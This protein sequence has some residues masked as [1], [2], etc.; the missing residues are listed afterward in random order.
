MQETNTRRSFLARSAL[1]GAALQPLAAFGQ[2]VQNTNT[3]SSP[4]ALRITDLKCAYV[5]GSLFVKI[6]TN[7][8][9]WGCGEAVDAIGG[10]YHMVQSMGRQLRN[11]SPL[12]VN[13]LAERIRKGGVFGGA[14]SGMFVAVLSAIETALWDLAGKALNVPVYQLLGGKFRDRIRVYCD[15]AFYSARDTGPA[16]FAKGAAGAVKAGYTAMKFDLDEAN[17]PNRYDRVNWTASPGEIQRMV[18]CLAAAREAVG[19]KVDICADM[20]GRYD[21]P[22]G[23][24]VAKRVEH[25]NLMYLEEPIPAENVDAYKKIADETSTPICAGENIY[26]AH[27]FRR[28]LEIGAWDIIMPDLQKVGGL[29]EGQRIANLAHLHYIPFA[30]HMVASYLGAMAS[31]HVCASVPNFMILE[32]QTYFDT[33]AMWKEIVTYDGPQVE[34]GFI[35]VSNKPGI[36]VDIN[37][38]GMRRYATQ[39]LPFFA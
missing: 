25:L 9:I 15:T 11:Q 31:A 37:E 12:N 16:A 30:P 14:Q 3:A 4:S 2:A 13:A 8:G 24:Q 38:E 33:Q 35:T 10:T 19:P 26:L 39:G 18:D 21:L 5:R 20:H 27:G 32:W 6:H 1:A 22:T 34:K 7:Q 29:G 36:G 28:G 17:D 23:L